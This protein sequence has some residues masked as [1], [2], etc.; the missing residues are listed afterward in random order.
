MTIL[1]KATAII[2]VSASRNVSL[3]S[4]LVEMC[5]DEATAYCNLAEYTTDLDNAVVQMVVERYNR[6]G[7][8]G[9]ENVSASDITNKFYNGY[10]KS[11][12]SMLNKYR[13]VK[14]I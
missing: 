11:T 12:L 6:R 1:E 5:T 9:V 10:S 7:Y 4:A 8:E 13:K 2:G 3:L 14:T